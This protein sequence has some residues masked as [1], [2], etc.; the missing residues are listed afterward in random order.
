[1]DKIKTLSAAIR[2]GSKLK[3]Q[4]I[5]AL[6]KF[7]AATEMIHSC[8]VGAA[9]DA[10]VTAKGGHVSSAVQPDV[11]HALHEHFGEI[12]SRPLGVPGECGKIEGC[13]L[14]VIPYLND[15][16][17]WSRERIADWLQENGL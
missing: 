4:A 6:F 10:V 9:Y 12:M 13:A 7:N 11:D 5:G 1:M 16:L 17:R 8:A 2:Y 3:P 14:E 15:S